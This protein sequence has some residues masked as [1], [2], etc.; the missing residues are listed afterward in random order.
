VYRKAYRT[1]VGKL[2]MKEPLA[3]RG[4]YGRKIKEPFAIRGSYG[5]KNS[6]FSKNKTEEL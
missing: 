5:K 6:I 1:F 2:E 4:S 3:I